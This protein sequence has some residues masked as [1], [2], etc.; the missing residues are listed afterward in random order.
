MPCHAV[1]FHTSVSNV[2]PWLNY[3]V[4]VVDLDDSQFQDVEDHVEGD[5]YSHQERLPCVEGCLM[6]WQHGTVEWEAAK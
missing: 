2:H 1:A 5:D 3:D 4:Q 6:A